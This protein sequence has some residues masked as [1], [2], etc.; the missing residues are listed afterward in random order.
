MIN[1]NTTSLYGKKFTAGSLDSTPFSCI[2]MAQ[3]ET[4]LVVGISF[5]APNNRSLI[6]TFKI[7]DVSFLGDARPT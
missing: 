1:I 5:D 3:N 4:F 2:G 7:Q 6:K